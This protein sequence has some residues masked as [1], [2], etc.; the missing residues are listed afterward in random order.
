MQ[1]RNLKNEISLKFIMSE[2]RNKKAR[3]SLK[4]KIIRRTNVHEKKI[5]YSDLL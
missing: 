4:R 3:E 5:D 1:R 2:P